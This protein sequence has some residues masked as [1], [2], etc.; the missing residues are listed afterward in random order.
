MT[1][2]TIFF[3]LLLGNGSLI[4]VKRTIGILILG[5]IIN[6]LLATGSSYAQGDNHASLSIEKLSLKK[7]LKI[8]SE[9][10]QDIEKARFVTA[11]MEA[12]RCSSMGKFGPIVR[13]E[14]NNVNWDS[15]FGVAV[16]LPIPGMVTTPEIQIRDRNTTQYSATIIQPITG[17]WTAY[18]GYKAQASAL[19][20]SQFQEKATKNDVIFAVTD[21]YIQALESQRMVSIAEEGF[22][23]IEAHTAKARRF[24]ENK[25]IARNDV[26]EAEV[27]KAEA[28]SQ[29][30]QAQGGARLARAN[31]SYQIG[32]PS[33]KE[34]WPEELDIK[35]LSDKAGSSYDPGQRPELAVIRSKIEQADAGESAARSRMLPEI[36][37]VFKWQGSEGL[38]MEPDKAWMGGV[39]LSWNIWDWGSTYYGLDAAQAR[40]HQAKSAQVKAMEGMRLEI[41]QAKIELDTSKTQLDVASRAV[42]QAEMNLESVQRRFDVQS[43]GS[44]EV[45]DA[46]VLLD[47]A[48]LNEAR[49]KYSVSRAYVKLRRARGLDPVPSEGGN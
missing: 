37:A 4:M 7:C 10:N 41:L 3:S 20:A 34:I 18:A 5:I 29:L 31:L 49:A 27:R 45:L 47:R 32:L 21:A 22:H 39:L 17:L 48:R 42:A 40:V 9:K 43:I 1:T 14:A 36:N 28:Q 46:Q 26:L 30:I 16:D 15:P 8:A 6:L 38:Y 2:L 35:L 11:E 13:L 23:V 19:K 25:L 24:F 44:T 33:D 12:E